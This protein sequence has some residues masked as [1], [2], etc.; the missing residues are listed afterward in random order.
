MSGFR[1]GS[2]AEHMAICKARA[3]E[4]LERGDC[5]NAVGSMN[6]DLLKHPETAGTGRAMAL[7]GMFTIRDGPEAV[8]R[9]I[10]GFAE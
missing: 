8:R 7:I 10:E 9:W 6:S 1:H 3:L 2:R 4:Y 5:R